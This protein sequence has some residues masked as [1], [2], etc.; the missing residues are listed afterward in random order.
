MGERGRYEERFG[1]YGAALYRSVIPFGLAGLVV[2]IL[3]AALGLSLSLLALYPVIVLT[4]AYASL[5][6]VIVTKGRAKLIAAALGL[7]MTGFAAMF[8]W[9][10]L[11]A[12]GVL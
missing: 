12:I 5:R 8:A 1:Q 10:I 4:V 6:N 9:S 3:P 7:L 2:L 11:A